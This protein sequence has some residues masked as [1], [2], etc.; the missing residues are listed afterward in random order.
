QSE[1]AIEQLF[2]RKGDKVNSP[3]EFELRLYELRRRLEQTIQMPDFYIT[4]LSARTVIYKGLLMPDQ[5]EK[6]Y[7]ELKDPR[8]KSA[9]AVVHSRYSTN[10]FPAWNLAQPFRLLAHNGEINTLRG[11]INWLKARGLD[12]ILPGG[13]DSAALDNVLE[14]LVLSGRSLPHALM[15]LVPQAWEHDKQISKELK[16]FYRYHAG[17]MEP[18][19]GPAALAV[20]DGTRV[21][22]VLDRNGLRP[23]RYI[24][25]DQDL[26]VMA[27]EVGVLDIAPGSIVKSGRLEPGKILF[28]DTEQGKIIDNETIKSE[29]A[30]QQPY[31]AW[32]A[33]HQVAFAALPPAGPGERI[34]D[35]TAALPAFGYTREDL[36]IIIKPM[37]EQGKEPIGSMGNDTPPAVLSNKPQLLYNYFRQLF[38]QVTNPPI[39]PIREEI[40]MSL[41]SYLGE[42]Q[43]IL[44]ET[45]EHCRLVQLDEPI[46]TDADLAKIRTIGQNG[47]KTKAISLLFRVQGPGARGVEEELDRICREAEAALKEGYTFLLLTD[48]GVDAEHAALPALLAVGG[49]HHHLIRKALRTRTSIILESG[50]PREVHHFALLFGYGADAVNPYLAYA[51]VKLLVEQGELDLDAEHALRHFR[52]AVNHGLEKILSKMGIST[53]R[54]YRGAQIFEAVGIGSGVIDRCFAGTASPL[55]GIGFAVV[56]EEIRLRHQRA[57]GGNR[58]LPSGGLYQWRRDGEFH[59]WNPESIAA[60]QDAVKNCDY[61]KFKDFSRLIDDQSANPT[62]LRGLLKFKTGN[63]VP[64]DQVEPADKIVKRFATGA[65]S[66]GSI[67]RGTHE[68]LALAM[69]QL[70]GKSNTGEGGEDP[71]RFR[72]NRRSAIKQ[73]ASGRFGVN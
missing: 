34:T 5:V 11:N 20:T 18:W 25:T 69:N 56:A 72:D 24:V 73:V 44:R 26:V 28:I 2:I 31:S 41:E 65:M 37:A 29:L 51:A 46:L 53:L 21:G 14:L 38:A 64:L 15:M 16:D 68:A 3:A 57:F 67:S 35:L 55:A 33:E 60:F 12:V 58:I 42:Q 19:D 8:V 17:F 27:S 9:L 6:F 23:A 30:A 50:E 22:A 59:L 63:A 66:F 61:A 32:L 40:V 48:R 70:G 47:F 45:P 1:P 49:L 62:T 10:T 39:D 71:E 52:I 43:N 54:S 4:N 36:R 7:P 13:S